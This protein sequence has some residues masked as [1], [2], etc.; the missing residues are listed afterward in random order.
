M[1]AWVS[2]DSQA[3]TVPRHPREVPSLGTPRGSAGPRP[4]TGDTL[5][6]WLIPGMC[7]DHLLCA[8]Q[9]GWSLNMSGQDGDKRAPVIPKDDLGFPGEPGGLGGFRGEG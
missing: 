4:R 9:S 2:V 5:T 3:P 8:E 7:R 6:D 1:K